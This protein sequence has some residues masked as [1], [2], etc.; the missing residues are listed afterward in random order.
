MQLFL[1]MF[2]FIFRIYTGESTMKR[3]FIAALLVLSLSLAGCGT[4]TF[5]NWSNITQGSGKVI[6]ETRPVSGFT[7]IALTCAGDIQLTQ[8]DTESLVI[9]AEDNIVPMLV[10]EVQGTQLVLKTRPNTSYSTNRG[11][12][13]IITVKDL[14]E[15][16]TSASGNVD[17]GEIKASSLN[18]KLSGSGNVTLAGLQA[19]SLRVEVTGSGNAEVRSGSTNQLAVNLHGSGRFSGTNLA[20]QAANVTVT[21]SGS[22]AVWAKASLSATLSGSGDLEYYGSPSV[23][24]NVSGS[25]RVR[26]RGNK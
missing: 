18:L 22:A 4:V 11:V 7:S 25:G 20:S 6:R 3:I 14:S 1:W 10:S 21:G 19:S 23:N 9:E 24:Q 13:F 5:G 17:A 15:I 2:V 26:S 12:H 8:G 16:Q